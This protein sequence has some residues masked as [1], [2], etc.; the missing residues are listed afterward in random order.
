M[1]R[2]PSPDPDE[3]LLG[4]QTAANHLRIHRST[5]HLAVRQGTLVPDART[6]GGHVRFKRETLD[7]YC[8]RF[9]MGGPATGESAVAAPMRALAEL[10]Q[11]L[12]TTAP[13]EAVGEAAVAG[14]RRALPG[15]DACAVAMVR[16]EAGD[17]HA[18]Q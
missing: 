18:L 9:S 15:I 11:L 13:L 6:A 17:P 10:A 1:P 14:V 7:A 4:A 3:Q 16:P 5:L 8:A 2:R 12:A